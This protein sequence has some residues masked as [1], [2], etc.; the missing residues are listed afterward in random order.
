[1]RWFPDAFMGTIGQV[2]RAVAGTGP[3]RSSVDDNVDTLKLVDALYRSMDSGA[4]AQF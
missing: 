1:M 3:L 2:F 4:A